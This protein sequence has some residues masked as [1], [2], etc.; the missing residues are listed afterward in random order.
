MIDSYSPII[1]LVINV[2]MVGDLRLN[3]KVVVKGDVIE[4][5]GKV[6][7]AQLFKTMFKEFVFYDKI[8]AISIPKTNK[9][10]NSYMLIEFFSI[11]DF[12]KGFNWQK[13]LSVTL[14]LQNIH[15]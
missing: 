3:K 14:L 8:E 15:M 4:G 5:D 7:I 2:K 12:L 10:V 1:P 9:K 6:S 13:K 11:F